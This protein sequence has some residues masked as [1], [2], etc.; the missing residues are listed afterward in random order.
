MNKH[1]VF[2]YGTLRR[3]GAGAMSI[4]FPNSKL[5]ADAK[6]SGSLYDLGA[7]PRLLLNESN[8]MVIGE[9]YEVDDETLNKLDDFE[10]SSNYCRKQV[11][12]PLGTRRRTCWVYEPNLEFYSPGTLITSGDWK[13]Y[14]KTKTDWRGATWPDETQS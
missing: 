13:E 9:V 12:I 7:Y 2:V 8:S 14:A 6:V 11:E 5:I 1:L 3:G 10:A 4:T